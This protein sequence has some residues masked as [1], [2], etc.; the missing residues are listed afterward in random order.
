MIRLVTRKTCLQTRAKD[1]STL[2]CIPPLCSL[3]K[4]LFLVT[5]II[6]SYTAS[7]LSKA[8]DFISV[9]LSALESPTNNASMCG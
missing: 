7:F 4:F 5:S 1:R 6:S 8:C 9:N 3:V 2:N